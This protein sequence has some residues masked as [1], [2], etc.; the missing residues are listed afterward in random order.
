MLMPD[1]S[2]NTVVNFPGQRVPL[3]TPTGTLIDQL[4][5]SCQAQLL[6]PSIAA[7]DKALGRLPVDVPPNALQ[8]HNISD[9]AAI[10]VNLG[11]PRVVAVMV[12]R[13]AHAMLGEVLRAVRS[14]RMPATHP[15]IAGLDLNTARGLVRVG[16]ES[17]LRCAAGDP[18]RNVALI[19]APQPGAQHM[20]E[21]TQGGTTDQTNSEPPTD[22]TDKAGESV[23]DQTAGETK[24]QAEE[25]DGTRV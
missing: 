8:M 13:A 21:E 6:V 3:P 17:A 2:R 4:N 11:S 9:R 5:A 19:P 1:A 15:L 16:L 24:E 12:E 22:P 18:Q 25:K 7:A 10:A 14:G 20:S 23:T